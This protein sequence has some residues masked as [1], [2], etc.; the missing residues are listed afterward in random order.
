[1]I[2]KLAFLGTYALFSLIILLAVYVVTALGY[3][4]ALKKLGY[5]NAW[6]GWIP[7][8]NL[9]ALADAAA[10]GEQ[11]I[12]IIGTIKIPAILYKFWWAVMWVCAFIPMIGTIASIAVKVIVFGHIFIRLFAR[13]TYTS[14]KDQQVMG[15]VSAFF[16]IV[17]AIRF[18]TLK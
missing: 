10:N 2:Y 5:Q 6:L 13:L 17:G 14:E 7:I 11:E 16:P 3:Y 15:Y 8:A 18:L 9:Y 1:M 12:N 4:T